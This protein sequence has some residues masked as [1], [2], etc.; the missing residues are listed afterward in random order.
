MALVKKVSGGTCLTLLG[1]EINRFPVP[2]QLTYAYFARGSSHSNTVLPSPASSTLLATR[3]LLP[4]P[5]DQDKSHQS[6]TSDE[7]YRSRV[8]LL[9]FVAW[10]D[11]LKWSKDIRVPMH[12]S[13]CEENLCG[14]VWR[15]YEE[16][17]RQRKGKQCT[18]LI[19]YLEIKIQCFSS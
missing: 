12:L 4:S 19:L 6:Y 1:N 7:S 15:Q 8:C 5:T 14:D 9:I 17:N 10:S 18:L 13:Q 11:V 16:R 2:R 3:S